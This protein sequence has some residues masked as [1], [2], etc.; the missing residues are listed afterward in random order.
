MIGM[1]S[2][3]LS[4]SVL[5][6]NRY[7]MAIHLVSLRQALLLLCRDTAEVIDRENGQYVNYDLDSW[8]QLSVLQDE[9]QADQGEWIRL[10]QQRMLVPRIVRLTRFDRVYHQ[11]LRF[12]RR[13]LFARDKQCCQYCGAQLTLS[14]MSLDHVVPRSQGGNTNWENIVCCCVKCN[15]T[16]GGRTPGEARMKLQQQPRKPVQQTLLAVEEN[17]DHYLLWKTFLVGSC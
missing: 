15:T 1:N 17:S 3:L 12:N 7:Y 4:S 2:N 13:N 8:C 11:P 16:K 5:V 9:F 10:V 6:L 14:Q